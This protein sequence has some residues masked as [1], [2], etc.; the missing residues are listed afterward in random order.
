LVQLDSSEA[1]L[2]RDAD[3]NFDGSDRCNTYRLVA[4]EETSL[5]F[6]DGTFDLVISSQA[7]HWV[8]DLPRLF[9]EAKASFVAIGKTLPVTETQMSQS[10]LFDC[11]PILLLSVMRCSES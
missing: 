9:K 6:P 7:L 2:H 3:L 4:D 8:N 5:P 1:M 11:F 10:A